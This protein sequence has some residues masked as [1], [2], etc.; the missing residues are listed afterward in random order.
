MN[1]Y[2]KLKYIC[3]TIWYDLKEN[4]FE[5][6]IWGIQIIEW[7][8]IVKLSKSQLQ[9]WWRDEREIIFTQEFMNKY[10]K[11]YWIIRDLETWWCFYDELFSYIDSPTDYLY[12]L[13]IWKQTQ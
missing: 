13:I 9:Q 11:F 4:W 2:E 7:W 10:L 1:K 5:I 12:D 6:V 3:D 8:D